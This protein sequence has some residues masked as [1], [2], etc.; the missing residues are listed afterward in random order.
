MDSDECELLSEAE[1]VALLYPF[2]TLSWNTVEIEPDKAGSY[3]GIASD[4]RRVYIYSYAPD[5]PVKWSLRDT[6]SLE[7]PVFWCTIPKFIKELT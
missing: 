2:E 6:G 7:V 4:R 3:L 5:Q 1:I